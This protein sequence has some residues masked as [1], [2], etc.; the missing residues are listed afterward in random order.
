M[1]QIDT[2]KLSTDSRRAVNIATR[3]WLLK[4][5]GDI[6]DA[7]V[8]ADVFGGKRHTEPIIQLRA[9]LRRHLKGGLR[10]RKPQHGPM[11]FALAGCILDDERG[12][13]KLSS[14]ALSTFVGMCHTTEIKRKKKEREKVATRKG[15]DLVMR[16]D[17]IAMEPY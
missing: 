9:R 7:G 10:C 8:L 15:C 6:A 4:A 11:E 3:E 13:K 14:L 17:H 5:A 2:S 16:T 1:G 12:W